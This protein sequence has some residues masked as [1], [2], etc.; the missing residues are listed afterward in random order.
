MF[1]G[2]V[3]LGVPDAYVARTKIKVSGSNAT[4]EARPV[5]GGSAMITFVT[6]PDGYKIELIQRA[7]DA[8]GSGLR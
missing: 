3:V 2:H 5:Q 7:E 4:C 1:Y 8:A 6:D